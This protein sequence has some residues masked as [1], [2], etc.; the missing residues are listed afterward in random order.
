MKQAVDIVK[1]YVP[2]DPALIQ[3]AVD[4]GKASV[5]VLKRGKVVR[6]VFRGYRLPGDALGITLDLATNQVAGLNVASHLGQPSNPVD[7]NASIGVLTDGT[8]YMKNV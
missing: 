3:R 7:M 4:A 6:L 8:T 1:S 5:E 2:P